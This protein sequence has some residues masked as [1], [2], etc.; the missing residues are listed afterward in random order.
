MGCDQENR[1]EHVPKSFQD[2][3]EMCRGVPKVL[4]NISEN[5]GLDVDSDGNRRSAMSFILFDSKNDAF[6]TII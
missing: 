4:V 6:E 1:H 3:A 5:Y 2:V